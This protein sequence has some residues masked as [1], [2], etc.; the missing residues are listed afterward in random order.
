M[1]G[2]EGIMCTDKQIT[3]LLQVSALNKKKADEVLSLILA[4]ICFNILNEVSKYIYKEKTGKQAE[5]NSFC[6]T[7]F[8]SINA[9]IKAAHKSKT[10]E[11]YKTC[12][13]RPVFE[14]CVMKNN[15]VTKNEFI[16]QNSDTPKLLESLKEVNE[17]IYK[18]FFKKASRKRKVKK[19]G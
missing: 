19:N 1:G 15:L 11:E 13:F 12:I 10:F 18:K 2:H 7:I 17:Q 9:S 14:V 6:G 5:Y 4:N 16:Q 3:E 8:T